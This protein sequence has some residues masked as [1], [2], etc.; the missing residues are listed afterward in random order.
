MIGTKK[1]K[2]ARKGVRGCWGTVGWG[3]LIILNR[4][5]RKGFT[6]KQRARGVKECALQITGQRALNH[7]SHETNLSGGLLAVGV[8]YT[9]QTASQAAGTFLVS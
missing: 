9:Q 2:K 1:K 3:K 4:V 7:R 6:K 5:F 8:V